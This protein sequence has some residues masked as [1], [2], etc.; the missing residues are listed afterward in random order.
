MEV[1]K[2]NASCCNDAGATR[3]GA[4]KF[5]VDLLSRSGVSFALTKV[6]SVVERGGDGR[7][8]LGILTVERC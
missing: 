6:A 5:A 3:A 2:D 7:D 4:A 1:W 8:S